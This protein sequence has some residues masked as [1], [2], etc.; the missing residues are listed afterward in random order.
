MVGWCL[1]VGI[2]P[3]Y[4]WPNSPAAKVSVEQNPSEELMRSVRPSTDL[5]VVSTGLEAGAMHVP[6]QISKCCAMQV[7]DNTDRGLLLRIV[8]Q[9]GIF[10]RHRIDHAVR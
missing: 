3:V 10:G 9:N 4:T 7:A 1:A 8:Q 5:P 2:S 6:G